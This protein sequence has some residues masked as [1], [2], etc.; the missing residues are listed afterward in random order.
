LRKLLE[1]FSIA[2]G[3]GHEGAIG[4]RVPRAEI[5]DFPGYITK[6]MEGIETAISE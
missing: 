5:S 1:R 2:N 6:L 3:G 4:F